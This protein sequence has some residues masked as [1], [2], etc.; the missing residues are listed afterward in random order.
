[1][2]AVGTQPGLAVV[3]RDSGFIARTFNSQYLHP[4]TFMARL[5]DPVF[6]LSDRRKFNSLPPP[7]PNQPLHRLQIARYTRSLSAI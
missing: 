3:Q 6:P 1:V 4:S 2:D 5:P 7:G